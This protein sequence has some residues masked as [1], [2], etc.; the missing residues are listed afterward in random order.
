MTRLD[1]PQTRQL[2][3]EIRDVKPYADGTRKPLW[4]VSVAPSLGHQ[5]VAALRLQTGVDAFYDW[6]GGLVWL[7]MEA[8]PEAELVRRY[9]KV[10]GGGHATLVR[11]EEGYRAAIPSFE[12]QPLAVAQL[13]ERVRAKF[14]PHRIFNPGRMAAVS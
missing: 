10:L 12:P 2:W 6:Q 4:R 11:A 1:A 9:I 7:R 5:L 3:A 13:S 8:D 14:D